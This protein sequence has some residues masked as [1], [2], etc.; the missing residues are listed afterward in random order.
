MAG[1]AGWIAPT[2]APR[3]EAALAPMLQALAHRGAAGLCGYVD[4]G[5]RHQVVLGATWVDHAA[6]IALVVDGTLLNAAELRK[7]LAARGY[8]FAGDS[9]AEVLLRA[10]QHWDK[11][12]VKQLRGAFAFAV[13][14]AGKDRLLLARD[15]FGE[16]P[17][18][19]CDKNGELLFAS[20]PKA[21]LAAGVAARVE[22]SAV[23]DC[24]AYRYVPGT[25]TL[26]SGIRKLAPATCL[27]W[28]LGN[29][30]EVRYWIAPDRCANPGKGSG[31]PAEK[32][33]AV[34]EEAVRLRPADAV[35]LSGGLDSAVLLA[36]SGARKTFSLGVAG[37]AASELPRAARLAKHFGTEH[38][39]VVVA[40]QELAAHLEYAIACRDAPL[41]RPSDLALLRLSAEAARSVRSVAS[42]EG[43]DEILGG[44]RRY[45]AEAAASGVDGFP[46]RLFAPLVAGGR[47]DGAA[48]PL[49]LN[50]WRHTLFR[51]EMP[52]LERHSDA[53][54]AASPL[55][56]ALY[57]DQTGWLA[58]ELL[59]RNERL[60]A[61][62]GVESRL[63]FVDHRLA[64]YVSSL[65]DGERVRGFTTKRVLREAARGL[66]PAPLVGRQ[67]GFRLDVARWLREDLREMTLEHLRGATSVTRDYYDAAALDRV[68][69]EH[70]KGKKNHEILLWTLLNIEIWHRTYAPA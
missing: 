24:L 52:T 20:E 49:K 66:V 28:Q 35:L 63:P 3:D 36:V 7:G 17:L 68:L 11:D 16:K 19:L 47:F 23:W 21:L 43:A 10:Y 69:D 46:A 41:A 32:F 45:V 6:R 26:F 54:A 27:A 57:Q 30:R 4:R 39:E 5:A 8:R 53:D 55:R 2:R 58:D 67:G 60:S 18:Y 40:P 31:A 50:G 33:R 12:L 13:W 62:A 34:L 22:L 56:R 70:L 9:E 37:D 51:R 1:I 44:Y 14:D 61:A 65:P 29:Q 48:A 25:R 42:G 64:E 38:C 15:R 59:E